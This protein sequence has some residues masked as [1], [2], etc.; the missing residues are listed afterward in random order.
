M[1]RRNLTETP[2][3]VERDPAWS[4][5]GK[6]I[7][8]FSDASGE[9][10]LHLKDSLGKGEA[11]KIRLE[12][13][14]TFYLSPRWSPDSK[15]IAYEDAHLNVWYVDIEQKKPVLVDKDRYWGGF[16]GRIGGWSPDSKWLSYTKR[17][18]NYLGAVFLYGLAD[19]K[20]TQLTDGMSDARHPV[21]DK[22]GKYLYFTASTDAG[23]SLEPDI[24]GCGEDADAEHLPGS[25]DPRRRRHPFAPE[26]DEEKAAEKKADAP[27]PDP[28]KPDAPKL[29]Q[30]S[31]LKS[32]CP[33]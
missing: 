23:P 20:N 30:P 29:T 4:P 16:G 33:K 28:P 18:P 22:D 24:Q 11:Q 7:A 1:I 8:Y 19:A 3:V 2:G 32:K 10:E 15:K 17:L 12:E 14:P 5:D 13:K 26:S 21:F 9:Y 31:L 25:S 27:K 6:W